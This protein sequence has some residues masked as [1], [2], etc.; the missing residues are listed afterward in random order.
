M[1]WSGTKFLIVYL[2]ATV[3]LWQGWNAA[4]KLTGWAEI[5]LGQC[6]LAL[7]MLWLAQFGFA[8]ATEESG[9]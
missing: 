5:D 4:S 7:L 1:L 3:I 2:A 6:S 8:L 9:R